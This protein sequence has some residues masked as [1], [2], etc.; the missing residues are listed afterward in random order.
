MKRQVMFVQG[1]GAKGTHDEWDQKL[2]RSLER[3]L[4]AD[5]Q[6][7]YPR[8]PNEADPAYARWKVA[9]EN[10]FSKLTDGA[11]LVGHSIGGTILINTLADERPPFAPGGLFLGGGGWPSD[12]IASMAHLGA[13][14]PSGLPTFLYHGD[15]DEIVPAAHVQLYARALP[16]AQLRYLPGRDHQLNNDLS[17]VAADILKLH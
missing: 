3:E 6:I 1:G 16:H 17:D 12:E 4:G 15:R 5:F 2:V 10:E 8:M 11:L 7:R 13:N 14:L 9:L